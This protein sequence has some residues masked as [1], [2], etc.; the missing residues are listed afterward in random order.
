[1][2]TKSISLIHLAILLFVG[3]ISCQTQ[4]KTDT[5]KIILKKT[6]TIIKDIP[7]D[8]NGNFVVAYRDKKYFDS[9]LGCQSM[10]AGCN[11][12]HIRLIYSYVFNDTGQII[13]IKRTS[14][15]YSAD[16]N[17]IIYTFNKNHDSVISIKKFT[18]NKTPVSRWENLI[19]KMLDLKITTL[20]DCRQISDYPEF[21]DGDGV[22]VEIATNTEYRFYQYH[23]PMQAAKS[24]WQAK[25][26]EQVLILLDEEFN[27]QR[28]RLF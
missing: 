18:T 25:N 2:K 6:D 28:L 8:K 24:I 26:M 10:E 9:L 1:M 11:D 17:N 19:Q 16:V 3:L 12:L 13:N 7:L 20:P 5:N 21:T 14:R 22:T 15:S 23:E 4:I 27:F